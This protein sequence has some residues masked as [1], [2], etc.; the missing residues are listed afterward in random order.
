MLMQAIYGQVGIIDFIMYAISALIVVFITL[1]IHEWAHGFAAF[2]LGDSTARY[3]GRLTLNPLAHID[4]MGAAFILL[5]G[6]GWAKPVPVNMRSFRRPKFDMALTALAGPAANILLAFISLLIVSL[7]GVISF[8]L[9]ISLNFLAVIFIYIAEINIS[10]AVFNLIPIPPLDGSRLL[11]AFLPNRIYYKLM[12]YERYLSIFIMALVVTGA[13]DVPLGFLTEKIYKLVS[14]VPN[15][16]LS[17][18]Y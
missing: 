18:I 12:Q 8:F 13:L 11:S 1:P 17:I 3:M 6:Y 2:K 4:W 15:L 16:I 5:F 9:G 10:L 14:F 7:I